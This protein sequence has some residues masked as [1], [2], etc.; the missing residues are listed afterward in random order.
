M[1]IKLQSEDGFRVDGGY[2]NL[3]NFI[4]IAKAG[5][6]GISVNL[7]TGFQYVEIRKKDDQLKIFTFPK[8]SHKKEYDFANWDDAEVVFSMN[9]QIMHKE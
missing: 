1:E 6:S 7:F 8:K 5:Y 2:A 4:D 3:S 9:E